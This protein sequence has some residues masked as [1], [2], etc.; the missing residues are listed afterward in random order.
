M[1]HNATKDRALPVDR[2]GKGQ[3]QFDSVPRVLRPTCMW[4]CILD[5]QRDLHPQPMH[6]PPPI[7]TTAST[8]TPKYTGNQGIAGL[9]VGQASSPVCWFCQLR[10]AGLQGTQPAED[11]WPTGGHSQLRIVTSLLPGRQPLPFGW[12]RFTAARLGSLCPCGRCWPTWDTASLEGRNYVR[13]SG[14]S[15]AC[16]FRGASVK[17]CPVT[18][19]VMPIAD[20]R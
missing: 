2:F 20:F 9:P 5:S 10:I 16:P 13:S 18:F 3:P 1:P 12:C 19:E 7:H 15:L 17:N 6:D 14:P 4:T 11:S 8:L